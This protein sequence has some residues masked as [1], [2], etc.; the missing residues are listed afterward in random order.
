VNFNEAVPK[1]RVLSRVGTG[2]GS[3]LYKARC[4]QT[5]Q[6]HTVK[7]VKVRSSNDSRFLDEVKNEHACGSTLD[8]PSVRKSYELHFI[9]RLFRV[10][11]AILFMEY[12]D[13]TALSELIAKEHPIRLLTLMEYVAHGL[14]A[15]HEG[16]FVHADVKPENILVLEGGKVK[17][18]DFG[19][20]TPM[21]T[22]KSRV[23]GTIDY[24]AP[25]QVDCLPLNGRTDVFGFGATMHHVL[26]G[27]P[28]DTRLNEN[29]TARARMPQS[30]KYQGQTG[31]SLEQYPKTLQRFIADCC[32]RE[33]KKRPKDMKEVATRCRAIRKMLAERDPVDSS[34]GR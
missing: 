21:D 11:A 22:A 31:P 34:E 33:S 30:I 10:K 16:G 25:E 17:L 27:K 15:M 32:Q 19:Q 7:C 13:G 2:A 20:S 4:R 6:I 18:I 3:I 28:I 12:V 8:H 9:R 29:L 23:Q 14:H 1:Y 24:I 26:T 5:G